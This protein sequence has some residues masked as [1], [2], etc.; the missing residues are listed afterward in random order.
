MA[1][2]MHVEAGRLVHIQAEVSG[3]Q[4]GYRLLGLIRE[5]WR[6]GVAAVFQSLSC[7]RL[8]GILWTV[9]HQASGSFTISWSLLKLTSTEGGTDMQTFKAKK[10]DCVSQSE[11]K[12][13]R[14]RT[15]LRVD[16]PIA[17][18]GG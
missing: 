10:L 7:A 15:Q 13:K 2:L 5:S 4:S 3:K 8:F 6:G 1:R 16:W 14:D 17:G 18:E 11:D 12:Q 9:A